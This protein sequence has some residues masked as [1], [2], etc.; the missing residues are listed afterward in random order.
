MGM[1]FEKC[2]MPSFSVIG[3]EGSTEDGEGFIKQLWEEA[4]GNF[5]EIEHLALKDE[6]GVLLGIWGLMSDSTRSYRPW[7]DNFTK[8]LYLAGAQVTDDAICPSGWVKWTVPSYEYVYGKVIGDSREAF[9]R[10][11]EYIKESGLSLVG[12]AFDYFCPE[13]DGQLYFF[14]PVRRL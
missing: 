2:Q 10:G 3:K 8:G 9:V 5:R 11:L 6:S 7:E 12:A 1:E 13:E 4:N 14:Y